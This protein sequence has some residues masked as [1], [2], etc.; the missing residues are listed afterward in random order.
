MFSK[1]LI[2]E[3]SDGTSKESISNSRYCSLLSF[4]SVMHSLSSMLT[5]WPQ[6]VDIIFVFVAEAS[7]I[8]CGHLQF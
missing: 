7:N 3:L 2:T 1:L 6:F 4:K 8:A 5:A